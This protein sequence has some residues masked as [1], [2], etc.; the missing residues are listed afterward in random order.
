MVR[1]SS[2]PEVLPNFL[3]VVRTKKTC[4]GCETGQAISPLLNTSMAVN[5]RQSPSRVGNWARVR[6]PRFKLLAKNLLLFISSHI[7]HAIDDPWLTEKIY[8]NSGL[9]DC[10]VAASIDC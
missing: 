5:F 1:R 3:H 6:R 10:R 2:L 7:D 4:P 9:I 8:I